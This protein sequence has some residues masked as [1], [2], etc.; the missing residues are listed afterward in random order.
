VVAGDL[1]GGGDG[2]CESGG[3]QGE[4]LPAGLAG[5]LTEMIDHHLFKVGK[6]VS[7]AG[8]LFPR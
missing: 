4:P 1:E 6:P 3:V 2:G 5:G 8:A 7:L